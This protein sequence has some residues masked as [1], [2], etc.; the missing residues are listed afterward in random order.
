[1]SAV[2][3]EHPGGSVTF[4]RNPQRPY[5]EGRRLYTAWDISTGAD[6]FPDAPGVMDRVYLLDW[7]LMSK[8]DLDS[9]L[10]FVKNVIKF[11]EETFTYYDPA[12]NTHTVRLGSQELSYEEVAFER[13]RVQLILTEEV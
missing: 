6:I 5:T 4:S 7:P 9:L 10:D 8:A 2:R 3:F 13:Y 12:G 1:M 11:R